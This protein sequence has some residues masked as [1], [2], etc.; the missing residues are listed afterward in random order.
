MGFLGWRDV[1]GVSLPLVKRRSEDKDGTCPRIFCVFSNLA[2]S[3]LV[4]QSGVG[5]CEERWNPIE[6]R[7]Y[8]DF[9]L[10]WA[11]QW[12]E[13]KL[14]A[15]YQSMLPGTVTVSTVPAMPTAADYT[16]TWKNT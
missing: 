16:F 5:A 2:V 3:R 14:V 9:V 11:E 10:E 12:A 8:A 7:D 6:T 1:L 4:T 15:M 13:S